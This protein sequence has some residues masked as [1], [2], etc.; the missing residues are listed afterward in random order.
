MGAYS[1]S[2][3]T[4]KRIAD[5]DADLKALYR[6]IFGENIDL[7]SDT[8]DGQLIG[9][10]AE[11]LSNQDA[12]NELLSGIIN[13]NTVEGNWQS[14][15]VRLNGIT[16]LGAA[17]STVNL[18]FTG[19]NGIIIPAGTIVEEI[20]NGEKFATNQPAE[21]LG[22]TATVAATAQNT[23]AIIALSGTITEMV[24]QISGVDSVTN[25]NDATLGRDEESDGDLRL[26]RFRSVALASSALTDSIRAAVADIDGVT[27]I[28]VYENKTNATN[29]DGIDPHSVAVVVVGGDD[30]EIAQTI[31]ENMSLG[32]TYGSTTETVEDNQGNEIDIN[33]S[34]PTDVDIHIEMDIRK[35]ST[36]PGDGE[37][38]IKAAIIEYMENNPDTKLSI[39]EDVVYSALFCPIMSVGGLSVTDLTI[40]TSASPTDK[41][42]IA[43]AFDEI[44][45]FD[46]SRI[47]INTVS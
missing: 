17:S 44:A 40:G 10:L 2:G 15:L 42:D 18:T 41:D 38:Q 5:W 9:A 22:G 4:R 47:T 24:S 34:R 32:G 45:E 14:T 6:S 29:A 30:T 35:F 19:T 23:G 46:T 39:G 3:Y 7:S 25:A 37:D 16:R 11:T 12:T 31:L 43:I 13:P 20:T 21:I 27:N 1:S 33:F 8:Q 36:F 28:R 26:R